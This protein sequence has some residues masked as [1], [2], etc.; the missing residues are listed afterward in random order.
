MKKD[1]KIFASMVDGNAI[2]QIYTIANLKAFENEKIRIMPDTHAGAGCVIGFTSTY[3]DKIIPNIVGVDISCGMLLVNMGKVDLDLKRIDDFIKKE[4]PM[5]R[6]VN[7]ESYK[8]G[9]ML[10][11]QKEIESLHCYNALKNKDLL[12]NSVGSLGGGGL[13][14]R[15]SDCLQLS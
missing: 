1:L 4:I 11:L 6:N 12:L 2:N 8:N 10:L 3:T 5:G 15:F 13:S 14:P 9:E 7:N